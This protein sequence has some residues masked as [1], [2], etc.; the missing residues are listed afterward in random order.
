ME[1]CFKYVL[2][3][4]LLLHGVVIG[5]QLTTVYRD[6]FHEREIPVE[7]QAFSIP[8]GTSLNDVLKRLYGMDLAPRPILV[9]FALAWYEV[10]IVVKKGDYLLPKRA[11][12]WDLLDLFNQGRV[13]LHK[14]TLPEG[15]DKWQTAEVLALSQWG[16][17]EEF[18]SL[19]NDPEHIRHLDPEAM[20]LEGYL[21]PET[22]LF[23]G[24]TT[25]GEIIET[26][27]AQFIE[28]TA[29][30]RARLGNRGLTL[31]E[32]ITLASMIEKE[33]SV[34]EERSLISG[35]FE[36]RLRRGMLLQCDPT[37]IYSLKRDKRYRGKIY[38]SQIKYD[39][40][41]KTYVYKGLPPG[42]IASP[43]YQSFQAALEPERTSYYYF[44]AKEDGSHHFS[45]S[46]REHNRAVR[47]Y[48]SRR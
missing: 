31:R 29:S 48:R 3:L 46:L 27:V 17:E 42:P 5:Y 26:M 38:K 47:K 9:R 19:I 24:E 12:T 30:L 40:P 25:P 4:L 44:V 43:S 21:F 15:L 18:L 11:S 2:I 34:D 8:E 28:R 10:E 7:Q 39:S 1:R 23:P 32:W 22:Y 35:V 14:I 33:A 6:I 20:D 45:K 36:N 13:R 16:T 41:Y 37:I